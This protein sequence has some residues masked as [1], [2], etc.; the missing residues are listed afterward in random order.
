VNIH[1][2]AW[3]ARNLF[4]VVKHPKKNRAQANDADLAKKLNDSRDTLNN[5]FRASPH[6]LLLSE[7]GDPSLGEKLVEKLVNSNPTK[8][9]FIHSQTVPVTVQSPSGC[10]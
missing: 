7:I 4:G 10:R 1:I 3:N 5:V 6:V 8:Y 2:V 9:R